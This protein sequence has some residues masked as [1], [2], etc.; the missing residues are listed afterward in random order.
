MWNKHSSGN[1]SGHLLFPYKH[2][3]EENQRAPKKKLKIIFQI[4]ISTNQL[5]KL[6]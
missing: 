6:Y 1:F 2:P 4:I 3:N 5:S